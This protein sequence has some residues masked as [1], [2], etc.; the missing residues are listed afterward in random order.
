MHSIEQDRL[1]PGEIAFGL[2][3]NEPIRLDRFQTFIGYLFGGPLAD[4]APRFDVH[5]MELSTGS[6][7]GRLRITFQDEPDDRR[8]NQLAIELIAISERNSRELV[9]I[10]SGIRQLIDETMR[11]SETS[12]RAERELHRREWKTNLALAVAVAAFVIQFDGWVR[13]NQ[14]NPAGENLAAMMRDDG[15]AEV[16]IACADFATRLLREDVPSYAAHEPPTPDGT[17]R[18]PI[19]ADSTRV[20]VD[21][22]ETHFGQG[23]YGRGPYGASGNAGFPG[24]LHFPDGRD[25]P[26]LRPRGIEGARAAADTTA[27]S[28]LWVTQSDIDRFMPRDPAD[29][30]PKRKGISSPDMLIQRADELLLVGVVE[31]DWPLWRLWIEGGPHQGKFIAVVIPAGLQVADSDRYQMTGKVYPGADDQPILLVEHLTP[32]LPDHDARGARL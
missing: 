4:V 16:Q 24:S 13:D 9:D 26:P 20:T 1:G 31:R 11:A 15:C 23:A 2:H 5:I 8:L 22:T 32:L 21:S 19:T 10:N 3:T 7:W 29:L 6:L 27:E 25:M 14:R 12:A 28:H 17:T 18:A 30:P